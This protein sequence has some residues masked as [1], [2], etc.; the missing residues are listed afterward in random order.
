MKILIV[1]EMS[2]PYAVGGGE[3]RYGLLTREL[4]RR[5]HVVTWLSMR[6]RESP[7]DEVLDGV[8]HL[9]RGPRIMNPPSRPLGAMLR[10]MITAFWHVLAH[11]YDVIDCQTYAPLPAV[12]LACLLSRQRMVATIHDTSAVS[13]GAADD[14]WL[15]TRDRMIVTPLEKRLYR[16]PYWR[17]V[18]GS[19]EVARVL[20]GR[21]GVS[22]HRVRVVPY[23]IDTD[24]IAALPASPTRADVVYVGRIIPH[25][26]VEDFLQAVDLVGNL[27]AA[28][29]QPRLTAAVV[30]GGPLQEAMRA[31]APGVEF[32]GALPEH[33]AVIGRI[34]SARVLVLPSTREGFGLVLTEAMACGTPCIAYDIPAIRETLGG[35]E[36]GLL[37]APRDVEGLAR[38][39][40]RLLLDVGERERLIAAGRRR[41][42]THFSVQSFT[43][44]QEATYLE[45]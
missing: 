13:S 2:V 16:L 31:L 12:W 3:V 32:T 38:T 20:I 36:A 4:A 42:A 22:P 39:I 5:G 30:G 10:F 41:V 25:K 14:Q 23:G 28:R 44:R 21:F 40:D 8:R 17:V 26:H 29:G 45:A 18:T 9:H 19:A 15:T 33:A 7:D 24:T 37:V 1:S 43:S 35:G 27:R 34:K 6:Q 11:R